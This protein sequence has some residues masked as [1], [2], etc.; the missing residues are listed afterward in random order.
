MNAK[1]SRLSPTEVF[2][3]RSIEYCDDM[4]ILNWVRET[5]HL[6]R[7]SEDHLVTELLSTNNKVK[8]QLD[9]V[10]PKFKYLIKK[11]WPDFQ[12]NHIDSELIA[13]SLFVERLGDYL[14]G[15][16]NPWDICRMVGPIENFY[17]FPRWLGDMYNACDWI[18]PDAKPCDNRHLEG[19]IKVLLKQI[20][21]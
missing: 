13:K 7:F 14:A 21:T 6:D 18:E 4:D 11:Y 1:I 19:E 20:Q 12:I 3:A 16:C 10:E 5:T 2:V 17:D 9:Q 15:K 8:E